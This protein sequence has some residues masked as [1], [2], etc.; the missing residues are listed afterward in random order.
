MSKLVRDIC[1]VF[2]FLVLQVAYSV[3]ISEPPAVHSPKCSHQFTKLVFDS[4][5]YY[6]YSFFTIVFGGLLS[7]AYGLSCGILSFIM[8]WIAAPSVR[9]WLIPM[10]LVGNLWRAVVKC[11]LDPYYES[12]GRIFSNIN[13]NLNHRTAIQNV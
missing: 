1:F 4:T 9:L 12:C 13:M 3:V 2:L 8:I 5:V 7:F 10:G 6:T 11:F